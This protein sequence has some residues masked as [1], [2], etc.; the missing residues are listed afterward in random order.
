[1]QMAQWVALMS[2][3]SRVLGLALV[4]VC[5]EFCMFSRIRVGFLLVPWFPLTVQQNM[6]VGG[7]AHTCELVH[8]L[9]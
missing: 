1:M 4:S 2:H 3:S 8:K 9:V 7:L 5:A 6:Q